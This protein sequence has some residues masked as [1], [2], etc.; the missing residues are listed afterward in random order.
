MRHKEYV[1]DVFFTENTGTIIT[2][3]GEIYIDRLGLKNI[4]EGSGVGE[5]Q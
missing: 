3:K 1:I 5:G 2:N 4:I